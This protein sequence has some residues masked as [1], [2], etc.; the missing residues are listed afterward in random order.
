MAQAGVLL[1]QPLSANGLWLRHKSRALR[2]PA[3][4]ARMPPSATE[5]ALPRHAG[6]ER[7]QTTQEHGHP[8]AASDEQRHQHRENVPRLVAPRDR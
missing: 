4:A 6:V 3:R 2:A 1:R 5:M 7:H 8:V